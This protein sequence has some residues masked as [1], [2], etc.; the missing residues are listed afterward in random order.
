MSNHYESI[1]AENGTY[2]VTTGN[3]RPVCGATVIICG[4]AV[5]GGARQ[6]HQF[7]IGNQRACAG[8]RKALGIRVS[9]LDEMMGR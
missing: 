1:T 2:H 9:A 7:T 4:A 3:G 8:C 5:L 6:A